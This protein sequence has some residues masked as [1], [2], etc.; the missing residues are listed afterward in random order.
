MSY[1]SQLAPQ[2]EELHCLVWP[3]NLQILGWLIFTRPIPQNLEVFENPEIFRAVCG[4]LFFRNPETLKFSRPVMD[5]TMM[6]RAIFEVVPHIESFKNSRF[7]M[8]IT[9]LDYPATHIS[10]V[11]DRLMD[12]IRCWPSGHTPESRL[13]GSVRWREPTIWVNSLACGAPMPC[14]AGSSTVLSRP[15][16]PYESER[17]RYDLCSS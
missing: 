9:P 3:G 2:D 6:F 4:S 7:V 12:Q 11:P 16:Y 13:P 1:W 5:F 15:N 8:T 17:Y 14:A 10:S